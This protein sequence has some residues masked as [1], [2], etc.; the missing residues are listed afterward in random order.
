MLVLLFFSVVIG[1]I[2]S[3]FED[4]GL[5]MKSSEGGMFGNADHQDMDI[6]SGGKYDAERNDHREVLRRKNS[7]MAIEVLAKLTESRKAMVLLRLVHFNMYETLM[8]FHLLCF[9]INAFLLLFPT[10]V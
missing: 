7:I 3:T 5:P 1:L 9:Q 2:D 4:L 6:D 10:I 8:F